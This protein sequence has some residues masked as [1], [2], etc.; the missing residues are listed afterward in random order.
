MEPWYRFAVMVIK[1]TLLLLLKREFRGQDRLPRTGGCIVAV[2]HVS[3][4]DPFLV[5]LFVHDAGRR[6]RYLAK[7]PL[8]RMPFVKWVLKGAK[9]IPVYRET[10][11]AAA[12]LRAAVDAVKGGECLVIYPEGTVTRDPDGWP[13]LAKT[14]VA[15]LALMTGAP[16][17]PVGQWGAQEFWPYKGKIDVLPRKRVEVRAGDPVELSKW[18]GAE[19]TSEHLREITNHIM[20]E[21]TALVGEIRGESPP[22]APYVPSAD[23]GE[24]RRAI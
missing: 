12:A 22:D 17:I 11:D 4:M 1:P 3:Y 2:N 24:T 13:M 23:R 15:R 20:G 6:P 10:S 18:D 14:G 21:I 9:Q 7:S 16:V 19:Q 8:F 5:A